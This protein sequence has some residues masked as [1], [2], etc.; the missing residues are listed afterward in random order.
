MTSDHLFIAA[1]L[2]CALPAVAQDSKTFS[3]NL[4][5]DSSITTE[6]AK[7]S[8]PWRIIPNAELKAPQDFAGRHT[9]KFS[10]KA[11]PRPDLTLFIPP[12]V[13]NN[14]AMPSNPADE[15]CYAIRSYVV[16]RDSKDSDA[17]HPAGYSTCRPSSRYHMKTV[18][19]KPVRDG[20]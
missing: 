5:T 18:E 2:C 17:T 1:L 15:T 20:R 11:M 16:A 4:E 7:A 8:E 6:P 19:A 13:A 12:M 9:F 3:Q 14:V 10:Q